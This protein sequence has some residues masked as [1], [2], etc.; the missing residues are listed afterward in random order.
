MGTVAVNP[1]HTMMTRKALSSRVQTSVAADD[2]D[3]ITDGHAICMNPGSDGSEA[4]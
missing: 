2:D 3:D 4:V 1:N